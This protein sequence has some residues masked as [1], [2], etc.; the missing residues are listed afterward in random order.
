MKNI[1][2][3]TDKKK[4]LKKKV[5][6]KFRIYL[7]SVLF[8]TRKNNT[9]DS[10]LI[11]GLFQRISVKIDILL[12]LDLNKFQINEYVEKNLIRLRAIER[13]RSI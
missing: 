4:G 6:S 5:G 7:C 9:N 12:K 13:K 2:F 1:S 8:L 10:D 3:E 11:H